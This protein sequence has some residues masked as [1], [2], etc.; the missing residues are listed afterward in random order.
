MAYDC[1]FE[2]L[3]DLAKNGIVGAQYDVVFCCEYGYGVRR[4]LK[5]AVKWYK[6][7]AERGLAAAQFKLGYFCSEG[8]VLEQDFKEAARSPLGLENMLKAATAVAYTACR[9]LAEP[10]FRDAV[11]KDFEEE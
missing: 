11:K 9:F 3:L 5:K 10:E 4:N 7:A 1:L 6:R 2:D 8:T